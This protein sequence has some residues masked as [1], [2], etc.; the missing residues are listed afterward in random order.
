MSVKFLLQCSLLTLYFYFCCADFLF[1]FSL[2]AESLTFVIDTYPFPIL[3]FLLSSF[4]FPLP[5]FF[6]LDLLD[7]FFLLFTS[8]L[9]PPLQCTLHTS[10]IFLLTDWL[11]R[12]YRG[13]RIIIKAFQSVSTSACITLLHTPYSIQPSPSFLCIVHGLAQPNR[14]SEN[15][16]QFS[17]AFTFCVIK[18]LHV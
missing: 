10:Y 2:N 11:Y 3:I 6:Y 18:M 15:M 8:T 4:L 14:K 12:H 1:Q 5:Q 9:F 16:D 13:M 17:I 7:S